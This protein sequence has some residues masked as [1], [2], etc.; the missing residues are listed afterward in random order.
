MGDTTETNT[1]VLSRE[2][3]VGVVAL[4]TPIQ[5]NHYM[6][7]MGPFPRYCHIIMVHIFIGHNNAIL[8]N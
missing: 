1:N 6:R 7:D 8:L 5:K 3:L 2:L 4:Q